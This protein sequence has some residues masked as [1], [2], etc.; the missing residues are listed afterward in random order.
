MKAIV[1]LVIF[2]SGCHMEMGMELHGIQETLDW[3]AD[4]ID[5]TRKNGDRWQS[6]EETVKRGKGD[7]ED[8]VILSVALLQ[9]IG[10]ES[11]MVV[12]WT[13]PPKGHAVLKVYR[14]GIRWY[15]TISGDRIEKPDDI[16]F[17]MGYTELMI[18]AGVR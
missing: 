2:L 14:G 4:N 13:D 1:L 7:C 16:S 11:A 17:E 3:V 9:E 8:F 12:H 10:V 15:E 5:Y 6:P 18:M